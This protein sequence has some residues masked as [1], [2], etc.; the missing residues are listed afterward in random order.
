MLYITE[1]F[2]IKVIYIISE[3]FNDM[4][5]STKLKKEVPSDDKYAFDL[6]CK[7]G[8]FDKEKDADK[9][10]G[11]VGNLEPNHDKCIEDF[12]ARVDVKPLKE[13]RS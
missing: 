7:D 8:T 2:N 9:M 12:T 13:S 4:I 6:L 5:K 3:L 10:R 1:L 11:L